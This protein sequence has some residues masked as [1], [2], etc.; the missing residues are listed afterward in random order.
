MIARLTVAAIA[1][2]ALSISA[3]SAHELPTD[4]DGS[5]SVGDLVPSVPTPSAA[6]DIERCEDD[7]AASCY[8][9]AER[10]HGGDGVSRDNSLSVAYVRHA[11]SLGYARACYDLGARHLLGEYVEQDFGQAL[12]WI[13]RACDLDYGV[14]CYFAGT[15]LRDGVGVPRDLDIS[16]ELFG[17]AC[18]LGYLDACAADVQLRV[19]GPETLRLPTG[20]E[21]ETAALAGACDAG[22]VGACADLADWWDGRV[23]GAVDAER[24][25]ERACDWGLLRACSALG[26]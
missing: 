20:V 9:L 17:R 12:T 14:A 16:G 26:R 8:R 24:L 13:D 23:H 15:L 10:L 19:D 7:E 4:A 18:G 6:A 1:A 11:C 25:R 22:F 2:S 21:G 3:P 5:P